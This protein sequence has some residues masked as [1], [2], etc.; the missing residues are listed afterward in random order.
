MTP[1]LLNEAF[2]A[3]ITIIYYLKS[4]FCAAVNTYV[5]RQGLDARGGKKTTNRH[6]HT[7]DNHSNDNNKIIRSAETH[8]YNI[9]ILCTYAKPL[10]MKHMR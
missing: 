1:Y 8:T 7:W 6:T 5:R 10:K 2:S 3:K 4:I 9:I